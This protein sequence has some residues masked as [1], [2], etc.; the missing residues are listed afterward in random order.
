MRVGGLENTIV[1]LNSKISHPPF[2]FY[3][4][5]KPK[6]GLEKE[7]KKNQFRVQLDRLSLEIG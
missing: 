4:C 6:S 3:S 2:L 1:A 7:E 5:F